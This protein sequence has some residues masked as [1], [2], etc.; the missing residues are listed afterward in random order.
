MLNKNVADLE[1]L[2]PDAG[3]RTT[4]KKVKFACY[5]RLLKKNIRK[6]VNNLVSVNYLTP[7]MPF[8]HFAL[9]SL[10]KCL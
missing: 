4:L 5:G 7:G 8:I 6:Q 10:G 3:L 2:I 9:T 1:N